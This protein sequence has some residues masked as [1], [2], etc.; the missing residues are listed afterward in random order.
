MENRQ[1]TIVYSFC[2]SIWARNSALVFST[3]AFLAASPILAAFHL[4][5][6]TLD[7]AFAFGEGSLRMAAWH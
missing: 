2:S 5:L 3:L 4:F 7:S 1:L 6:V